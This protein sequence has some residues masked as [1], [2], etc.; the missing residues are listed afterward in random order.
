VIPFDDIRNRAHGQVPLFLE[1]GHVIR[2][3]RRA[4][5]F[6]TPV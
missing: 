5:A 2:V 1:E 3:D 6:V 4:D